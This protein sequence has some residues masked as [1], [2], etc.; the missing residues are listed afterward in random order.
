[1]WQLKYHPHPIREVD[2][3]WKST[4]A[5]LLL[6][7][8]SRL[9]DWVLVLLGLPSVLLLVLFRRLNRQIMTVSTGSNTLELHVAV[10]AA[11]CEFINK[12]GRICVMQFN[13]KY[14]QLMDTAPRARG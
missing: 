9:V 3:R 14:P 13:S 7:F 12:Q 2:T 1:M 5:Y 4:K 6:G 11:R 10:V 8:A